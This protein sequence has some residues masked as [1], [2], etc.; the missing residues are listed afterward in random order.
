M[1]YAVL[2]GLMSACAPIPPACNGKYEMI[3]IHPSMAID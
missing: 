3:I 2:G 1:Q